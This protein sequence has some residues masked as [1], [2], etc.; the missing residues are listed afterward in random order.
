M[1]LD[2]GTAWACLRLKGG[3]ATEW[4]LL[5]PPELEALGDEQRP[6]LNGELHG[7]LRWC[8]RYPLGAAGSV[9]CCW[10][11]DAAWT[12]SDSA[13]DRLAVRLRKALRDGKFRD[14][15]PIW[16]GANWLRTRAVSRAAVDDYAWPS[17]A[18]R[19]AFQAVADDRVWALVW[20]D[21]ALAVPLVL[22]SPGG[23]FRRPSLVH[24]A[25]QAAAQPLD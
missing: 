24:L 8:A 9:E 12:E 15:Q 5:R 11:A 6:W 18:T 25:P 7:H 1:A 23:L 13:E 16:P 2:D 10:L 14:G 4:L 20:Q 22:L 17:P 19:A 21:G 3:W